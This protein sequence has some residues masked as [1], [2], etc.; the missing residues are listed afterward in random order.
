MY[1]NK[2]CDNISSGYKGIESICE[3]KVILL[4]C[5]VKLVNIDTMN[6]FKDSTSDKNN[7]VICAQDEAAKAESCIRLFC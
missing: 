7:R 5:F 3:W 6:D 1:R 4:W 2:E